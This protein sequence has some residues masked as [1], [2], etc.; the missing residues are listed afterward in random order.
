MDR[1]IKFATYNLHCFNNGASGLADLCQIADVVA[2][3][4]HWLPPYSLGSIVA[5][6]YT[7]LTL[8]TK[9]IV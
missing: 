7:H 6:S 4:E 9:R 1:I 5:V 8:P 2:V 3:Q